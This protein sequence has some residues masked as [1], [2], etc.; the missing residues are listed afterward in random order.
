M[1]DQTAFNENPNVLEY[2]LPKSVLVDKKRYALE[3]TELRDPFN[4]STVYVYRYVN[5][6]S[7]GCEPAWTKEVGLLTSV[8]KNRQ[9][10]LYK[11]KELAYRYEIAL[12][13]GKG[14]L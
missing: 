6:T 10:A 14:L 1:T 5:R 7:K 8:D 2:V 4:G 12:K 13:K 9:Q 3:Y 11:M